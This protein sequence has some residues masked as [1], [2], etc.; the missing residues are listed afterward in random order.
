MVIPS[1]AYFS[2]ENP[3]LRGIYF[4]QYRINY[5]MYA[6]KEA[7][8]QSNK[9]YLKKCITVK[10]FLECLLSLLF[11]NL[12]FFILNYQFLQN[13]QMQK[14]IRSTLSVIFYN[15]ILFCFFNSVWIF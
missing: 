9:T 13:N 2:G 7:K 12:L 10:L 4:D 1:Y 15:N 3:S 6:F 14:N 8:S 5:I 11:F